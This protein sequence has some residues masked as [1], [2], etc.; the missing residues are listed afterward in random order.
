MDEDIQKENVS[1]DSDKHKT[2]L[3]Y[4]PKRPVIT[5][6]D[7]TFA[8]INDRE[9]RAEVIIKK[10]RND[11][12][13][14][15]IKTYPWEDLDYADTTGTVP[16]S[17][18][19]KYQKRT[20]VITPARLR[21]IDA[22]G[23]TTVST[24]VTVNNYSE[25]PKQQQYGMPSNFIPKAPSPY[26]VKRVHPC[27]YR[28]KLLPT[29]NPNTYDQGSLQAVQGRPIPGVQNGK[30]PF[31]LLVKLK[32]DHPSESTR[33]EGQISFQAA[34]KDAAAAF[35]AMYD[36][37]KAEAG[38]T[39]KVSDSYRSYAKQV[40]IDDKSSFTA[41]GGTS[42]HGWG[43]AIDLSAAAGE[44]STVRRNGRRYDPCKDSIGQKAWVALNGD[45][46]GWYWGDAP[47]ESWHFV[48]VW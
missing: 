7:N 30:L 18:D 10:I 27:G 3:E 17:V 13:Q 25:P 41:T 4:Q 14:S 12:K 5:N 16:P 39:L 26:T 24:Y 44:A 11:R 46:F 23:K 22:S 9:E 42:N 15:N 34:Y 28:F 31:S 47:G 35:N 6:A 29:L 8:T 48:Y 2:L 38:I 21:E 45:R 19:K 20:F 36:A 43:K 37:A 32:G 33:D 1:V 40:R